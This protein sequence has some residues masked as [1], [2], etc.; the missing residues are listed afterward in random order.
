MKLI[1]KAETPEEAETEK[2]SAAE[3]IKQLPTFLQ[4]EAQ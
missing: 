1:T 4:K 2:Q 3:V